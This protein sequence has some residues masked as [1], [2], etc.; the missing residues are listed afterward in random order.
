MKKASYEAAVADAFAHTPTWY[1]PRG[2]PLEL[3]LHVV[4]GLYGCFTVQPP[5]GG[6]IQN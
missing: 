6:S 4:A 2:M 3:Q 5:P 1:V